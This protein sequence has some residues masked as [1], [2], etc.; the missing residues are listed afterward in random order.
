MRTEFGFYSVLVAC[1][2]GCFGGV[3]EAEAA[4]QVYAWTK[5]VGGSSGWDWANSVAVDATGNVY[6]AGG[7]EETV[8]FDPGVSTDIRTCAGLDDVFLSKYDAFGNY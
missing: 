8:D 7:F 2:L 5:A 6:V 4:D 3:G 1:M